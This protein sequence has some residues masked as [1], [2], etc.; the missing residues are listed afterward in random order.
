MDGLLGET[1]WSDTDGTNSLNLKI[2][3]SFP[4]SAADYESKYSGNYPS[5]NLS[6][7]SN[8]EKNA[9]KSV[10]DNISAV[11]ALKFEELTGTSSKGAVIRLAQMDMSSEAVTFLP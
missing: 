6:S 10:F 8:I 4:A 1:K 7:F 11:T 9:I 2:S 3:Y 5:K